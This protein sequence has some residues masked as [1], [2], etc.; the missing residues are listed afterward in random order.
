MRFLQKKSLNKSSK[1]LIIVDLKEH[2]RGGHFGPWLKWFTVEFLSRFDRIAIVTPKPKLTRSLF[3]NTYN[4]ILS[5]HRLSRYLRKVFDLEYLKKKTATPNEQVHFFLMWG[6]DLLKLKQINHQL[7]WATFFGISRML[8]ETKDVYSQKE[9]HILNIIESNDNC[10]AFFHLDNY[11]RDLPKKA[12]CITDV[13]NIETL[14]S[15]SELIDQ[16]ALFAK[17][18]L[19][20]GSFGHLTGDRCLNALLE[21]A[22]KHP[23]VRFVIAGKIK[24]Q[25]VR[26]DLQDDLTPGVRKNLFVYNSFIEN[27]AELNSA[28]QAV[29]AFFIDGNNYPQHSGIVC[30]ALYFGKGIISPIGNSWT[31]DLIEEAQV[32][33][34]Y[35]DID[36]DLKYEWDKWLRLGGQKNC[37]AESDRMRLQSTVRK[38]FDKMTE[39]L[40]Q[41]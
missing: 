25:T 7:P 8:R 13:E 17:E 23:S 4:G 30:K 2:T 26:D 19:T 37:R 6:Y 20:I 18:N 31:N 39:S 3:P 28:I 5:F 34:N 9:R 16:I 24:K 1:I 29:D 38:N 27:E 15:S 12:I 41:N 14:K 40:T 33:I 10:K 21:L 36:F 35:N 32:G 22:R 11:L